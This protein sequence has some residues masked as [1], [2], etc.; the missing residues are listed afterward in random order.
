MILKGVCKRT[1]E[2]ALDREVVRDNSG[3]Q[4]L[5]ADRTPCDDDCK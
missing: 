5:P 2:K 3:E 1:K 4:D